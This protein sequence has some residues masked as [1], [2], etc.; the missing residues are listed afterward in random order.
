LGEPNVLERLLN[1]ES[2]PARACLLSYLYFL[3]W[4]RFT[5][6][7]NCL[8]RECLRVWNSADIDRVCSPGFFSHPLCPPP[9]GSAWSL[10]WWMRCQPAVRGRVQLGYRG[11]MTGG[12]GLYAVPQPPLVTI[13]HY[14]GGVGNGTPLSTLWPP[15][16]TQTLQSRSPSSLWGRSNSPLQ[17]EGD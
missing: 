15:L 2:S 5:L 4:V 11:C 9:G 16:P 3:G 6:G 14:R 10:Q 7:I 17:A 1:G 12:T 8:F 13:S